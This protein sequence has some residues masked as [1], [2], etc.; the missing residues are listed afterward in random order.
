MTRRDHWRALLQRRWLGYVA[1]LAAVALLSLFI[2]LVLGRARID[3]I[4]MLYLI[5]VFAVAIAFG[6]RPAILASV[7]AFLIFD[8]FFVEPLYSITVSDPAEWVALLLFLLTAIITGQLTAALRRQA[9]RAQE[10]ERE[11]ALL[12][13]VVRVL[14][15][16]DIE[17][18][19]PSVAER[20]RQEL[21]LA[22]VTIDLADDG[23]LAAHA[24]TGEAAVLAAM[25]ASKQGVGR[26]LR[27][28]RP[29]DENRKGGADQWVRVLPSR[30][31]GQ[32]V[33]PP[34]VGV[35]VVPVQVSGRR[36]GRLT[37]VQRP[38]AAP[39]RVAETRLL[40]ALVTQLGLTV[41]RLRLQHEATEADALR[42][43]DELKTALLNAVSHDL[44]TPL[45]SI[46][47]SAGSLRQRDIAWTEAERQEFAQAI[48]E[49]ALRLNSIVGNLLDLS[50][51]EGGSLRPEKGWYD[52]G[53]LIDD[54]LGRLRPRTAGH[55]IHVTLP[56]D[57]PPVNLDYVEID[58]VL[59][60]LIENAAKY[61]PTGTA[62]EVTVTQR[63]DSMEVAVADRGPGI[64][65]PA[66]S[67]L[68]EPF[69]RVG[70]PGP[71]PAGAGVGL[72]VAKGLVEAHG[73][74]ISVENRAGGGARFRFT[75][76]LP[77]APPAP[78]SGVDRP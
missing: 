20:L 50:R 19:L 26:V 54:V 16:G 25:E 51:I 10:R 12:Y 70:G 28:G 13:D 71:R 66:L 58:Q 76:P 38:G 22:A 48:E 37:L 65:P 21:A 64:P 23:P 55:P 44:R 18:T 74:H 46:I 77:E 67:R 15:D 47:A 1:A 29:A 52:L 9:L 78:V 59:S 2:G 61:T 43:T 39:L 4:S 30:R 53:A 62:I 24:A 75:L 57:L 17:R 69:Y 35:H 27:L 14:S 56:A 33:P 8:W 34:G 49:E 32:D 7:A 60:N 11:A 5:A 63:P 72:T 31:P 40:A 73:G 3:N 41:E 68:F 45:A 6:S 42:R 36:I